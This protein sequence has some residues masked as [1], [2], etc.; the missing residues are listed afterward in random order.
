MAQKIK[1]EY[2]S[3]TEAYDLDQFKARAY[4]VVEILANYLANV[5]NEPV[6]KWQD[7]EVAVASW[8]RDFTKT[9]PEITTIVKKFIDESNH[10]HSPCYAGHQVSTP[11][12]TAALAEFV[13]SF[14]NSPSSIY[15]MGPAS[16]GIEQ[17][18]VRWLAEQLYI[19]T[20]TAGAVLTSGGSLGNLTAL[21]T[22]RQVNAGYDVWQEGVKDDLAIIVSDQ[23][24]YSISR[25][26]HI[27][28]LGSKSIYTVATDEE[29]KLKSSELEAV[30]Q[31]SQKDG[32][33][34][35]AVCASACSTSTGSYDDLN[36]IADF[37]ETHDLWLHV[38]G[39]HGASVALSE[40]YKH[41]I[42]GI[43]RADS[44]VWDAHKMMAIPSLI[45]AVIYK[46]RAESYS[47]FS[48]EASYL[49]DHNS[50]ERDTCNRTVECTKPNMAM[51]LY[52]SLAIHGEEFFSD[53]IDYTHD[54]AT[55]F[56]ELI[57][58]Q[59]D[60]E[61]AIEPESNIVCFRYLE[62]E[63]NSVELNQLQKDLREKIIRSGDFYLV[64]TDL[65]GKTYLRVS[66]MNP[67]TKIDHLEELL[68]LIRKA[69]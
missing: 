37:C 43:N 61:L 56:A 22:A 16:Y 44:V 33:K 38:D 6:L 20:E 55:R 41:L 13:Y 36:A 32:K 31:Q 28:G 5:E 14:L 11:L 21:L 48:Q 7:P 40:K 50:I 24:H 42:E 63:L 45:T 15:E 53:Y 10:L 67:L 69:A 68:C 17:A 26:A 8:S 19:N 2:Q 35:I 58:R 27:M 60:F 64:K 66:L 25:A 34:V 23:N 18:I 46:N 54:L 3:I 30:Y 9:T 65:R 51:K 52:L 47:T 62:K 49:L 12:P 29:F 59:D 1:S 4:Q 57:K 39:A